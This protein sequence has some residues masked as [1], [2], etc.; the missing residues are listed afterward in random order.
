MSL[1]IK[2]LVPLAFGVLA[3]G[4]FPY[5]NLDGDYVVGPVDPVNFP[6]AYTG[7]GFSSGE[8]NGT[9]M[10]APATVSSGDT[11]F[12]YV[13]PAT[14][15]TLRTETTTNG[16]LVVKDRAPVYVFDGDPSKDSDKCTP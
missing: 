14:S 16:M 6:P 4:C 15:A 7:S 9:F 10:A 12:Y 5:K 3:F 11:V 13:F 1:R 2:V 8:A